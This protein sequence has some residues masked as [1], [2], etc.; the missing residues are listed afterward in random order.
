MGMSLDAII[1]EKKASQKA[2]SKKSSSAPAKKAAGKARSNKKE[3][4]RAAPYLDRTV[5]D[6][7]PKSAG[8]G[9]GGGRG[10]VVTSGGFGA[11][12]FNRLG[13]GNG[14]TVCF[15]NLS[16]SVNEKDVSELCGAIG[17]VAEMK[18]GKGK[19]EVVFS[20]RNSANQCCSKYNGL[21]LDGRTMTVEVKQEVPSSVFSRIQGT[22]NN[23]R[24]GLFGTAMQQQQGGAAKINLGGGMVKPTGASFVGGGGGGRSVQSGGI[25]R[26]PQ[27][28]NNGRN[29]SQ[30]QNKQ[31]QNK[32]GRSDGKGKQGGKGR[33]DKAGPAKPQDLDAELDAYM[34][35]SKEKVA[36][37]QAKSLDDDMDSYFASRPAAA[38]PAAEPSAV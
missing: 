34:G 10:E 24:E 19:A 5:D 7:R 15:K 32:K 26:Q 22:P 28:G 30:Q 17:K 38:A 35:K 8:N 1:D 18:M 9:R 23:V 37:E 25:L 11:D 4:R 14:C 2:A 12:V 33:S 29:N 13:G 36:Q 16:F 31:Q 20:S 3:E 21:S 6:N 27:G